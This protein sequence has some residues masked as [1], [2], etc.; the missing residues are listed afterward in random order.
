MRIIKA[1]INTILFH[2]GGF[3]GFLFNR[4]YTRKARKGKKTSERTLRKII[5]KNRNTVYG[6]KY[7]FSEINSVD[8]YR[9]KVPL[10][11][12]DDYKEYVEEMRKNGTQGL[13]TSTR[14]SWFASTSG[15]TGAKKLIPQSPET[16]IELFKCV[17]IL[18]N[19]S[20][21]AMRKRKVST[22]NVRGFLFTEVNDRME[23][24]D[25]N[26]SVTYF[27]MFA[28][29]Y[30]NFFLPI[31]TQIPK[32]VLECGEI[33]EKE[34]I[35]ARFS[36]ADRDL[37]Y[38][39]GPFMSTASYT[40]NYIEKNYEM[41]IE[42][43]EK[44]TLNP[45]LNISQEI[46]AKIEPHLKPDPQRARELRAVFAADQKRPLY[47]AIW[48]KMS[49]LTAIGGGDF[50]PFTR[51]MMSFFDDDITINH[52]LYACSESIIGCAVYPNQIKY[53]PLLSS[54]FYEFIPVDASD[55]NDTRLINEL[56]EGKLYELV[57]T[58]KAGLY[59]YQLGDVVRVVGFCGETP[60]VEFAYRAN[61]VTNFYGVK[62]NGSSLSSCIKR[63]EDDYK[64]SVRDYSIYPNADYKN[65]HFEV[66][67]ELAEEVDKDTIAQLEES[68]EQ[69]MH[70]EH[71]YALYRRLG[72][73]V[74]LKLFV[75]KN[76]TYYNF[77]NSQISA[78]ASA[79]QLKALRLIDSAEKRNY[80]QKNII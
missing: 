6:K 43:I 13:I 17:C 42:D 69:Y 8:D 72:T 20:I 38:M 27:T 59:R 75:V 5:R 25:E 46:R 45:D 36:M 44:G 80:F 29:K 33:G 1:I 61:L 15:T 23:E 41:L 50:E 7:D 73:V 78:G 67:L 16:Y 31:F 11:T 48:P 65:P 39:A 71:G 10:S 2:I 35:K 18:V 58:T 26:G 53:L 60:L 40:V 62:L 76:G 66:Y 34:Y 22:I 9:K 14:I 3:L 32:Y 47:S 4:D 70:D 57:L 19:Q 74:P 79:N 52:S 56:E 55:R 68:F 24:D 37:K 30:M 54:A 63:L 51:T 21:K 28:A 12:Y 49:Y 77:R 64:L